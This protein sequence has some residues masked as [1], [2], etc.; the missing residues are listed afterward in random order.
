MNSG[1]RRGELMRVL[2]LC[3][4]LLRASAL[5]AVAACG[6]HAPDFPALPRA[7]SDAGPQPPT[8]SD[9]GDMTVGGGA[10]CRRTGSSGLCGRSQHPEAGSGGLAAE[11]SG[12]SGVDE[13]NARPAVDR[14]YLGELRTLC[15]SSGGAFEDANCVCAPDDATGASATF[16]TLG[17]PRCEPVARGSSSCF[18]KGF[19]ATLSS[20]GV[21]ALNRCLEGS[22]LRVGRSSLSI[23]ASVPEALASELAGWLD[24][25]DVLRMRLPSDAGAPQRIEVSLAK[26]A[27]GAFPAFIDHAPF[28][29]P[30]N[31]T[32]SILAR[33]LYARDVQDIARIV[34]ATKTPWQ[35]DRSQ[36]SPALLTL[37]NAL[38]VADFSGGETYVQTPLLDGCIGACDVARKWEHSDAGRDYRVTRTRRYHGGTVFEDR[39]ELT[40]D[41]GVQLLGLIIFDLAGNPNVLLTVEYLDSPFQSVV[42]A[43]DSALQSWG[44]ARY[45]ALA[46]AQLPDPSGFAPLA[47]TDSAILVC[48]GN[49]GG[50]LEA[51]I[52]DALVLGQHTGPAGTENAS[53]FGWRRAS[54]SDVSGYLEGAITTLYAIPFASDFRLKHARA[55]A[56][57]AL[58]IDGG[59]G[60]TPGLR[61]LP[62]S[63]TSCVYK[64]ELLDEISASPDA[65]RIRVLNLSATLPI[66]QAACM[67]RF[68]DGVAQQF[69]WVMASGNFGRQMSDLSQ[70]Q[71]CPQNHA[72]RENLLVVD[73]V[74]GTSYY[75]LNDY[76]EQYSDIAADCQSG[77]SPCAGTSVSAP[78]VSHVAAQIAQVHG[79]RISVPM[80]RAA[81]LLSAELP[82]EPLPNRSGGILA[83]ETALQAAR[84]LVELGH[85]QNDRLSHEQAR[86]VLE[87]LY[88]DASYQNTQLSTFKLERLERNAWFGE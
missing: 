61:V 17:S 4:Q 82:P 81:I 58:G 12:D 59:S 41:D 60:A 22:V 34:S 85:G 62:L 54:A 69:L 32:I 39:L 6:D 50:Q 27:P 63:E 19:A 26:P 13:T 8:S 30:G 77:N 74:I 43:Y 2:P 9:A 23:V 73:G 57:L 52:H 42:V 44:E 80:I 56:Q 53:F 37:L 88:G 31:K 3:A 25:T 71:N 64:P 24:S 33:G 45:D 78:R 83:P 70:A 11:H 1:E 51:P 5:L 49:F 75:E 46:E 36:A 28:P 48:E 18:S 21:T 14:D 47:A 68:P 72:R 40:S 86:A 15:E 66:D 7:G 35:P 76:G 16:T 84:M 79:D 87:M 29:M 55:V 20:G 38:D 10:S 65:A 67:E